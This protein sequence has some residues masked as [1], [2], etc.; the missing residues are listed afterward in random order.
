MVS[1]G[2]WA[3]NSMINVKLGGVVFEDYITKAVSDETASWKANLCSTASHSFSTY[4]ATLDT[5]SL[6]S[7]VTK[8]V[9]TISSSAI[10]VGFVKSV[11]YYVTHDTTAAATIKSVVADVV[12][13]DVPMDYKSTEAVIDQSYGVE[14][15]S[16]NKQ[17]IS[18]QNGN[19][20]TR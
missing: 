17:G 11:K 2:I 10:C 18:N 8:S 12:V 19:V 7:P 14:F 20:V 9:F 3:S 15:Y 4:N 6:S 1:T 16:V 13:T 5:C